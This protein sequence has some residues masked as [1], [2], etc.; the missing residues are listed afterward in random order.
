ML[1]QPAFL[2]V[3]EVQVL[4]PFV[5]Y[6]NF[7]FDENLSLFVALA[8]RWLPLALNFPPRRGWHLAL[9]L[10]LLCCCRCGNSAWQHHPLVQRLRPEPRQVALICGRAL[11]LPLSRRPFSAAAAAAGLVVLVVLARRRTAETQQ[12]DAGDGRFPAHSSGSLPF[13]LNLSNCSPAIVQVLDAGMEMKFAKY[14]KLLQ[15][16]LQGLTN[17]ANESHKKHK[18]N[19]DTR[20]GPTFP[21]TIAPCLSQMSQISQIS[22]ISLI[23]WPEN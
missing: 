21:S 7:G 13:N 3:Q 1:L 17:E 23:F 14:D 4:V 20:S 18:Q 15:Q 22:L 16:G 2:Q 12:T 6:A 19:A 8:V 5:F 11:W 10:L 9:L